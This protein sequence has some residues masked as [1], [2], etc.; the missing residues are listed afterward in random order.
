[1]KK[2]FKPFWIFV[3]GN[4][5]LLLLFLFLP[6]IGTSGEQLAAE[7]ASYADNFWGWSWIVGNVKFWVFGIFEMVVLFLTARAFIKV[8]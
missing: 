3:G 8:R 5:V 6:A 1:M 7:T 4:V 2:Y